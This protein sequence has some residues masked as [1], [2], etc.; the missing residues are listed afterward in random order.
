MFRHI[1]TAENLALFLT[2]STGSYSLREIVKWWGLFCL[3]ITFLWKL[4]ASGY[5]NALLFYVKWI[6]WRI[7]KYHEVGRHQPNIYK[8]YYVAFNWIDIN[9][10]RTY[11]LKPT[12]QATRKEKKIKTLKVNNIFLGW[13][14]FRGPSM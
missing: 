2:P 1:Y 8:R 4:V 3:I 9:W 13:R 11:N 14:R 5:F 7:H 6:K 12:L 10:S